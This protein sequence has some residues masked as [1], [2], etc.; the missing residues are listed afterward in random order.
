MK[1]I[2]VFGEIKDGG[3][4]PKNSDVYMEKL[5]EAGDVNDCILT[6]TGA[7]K[8]SPDQNNYAFAMCNVIAK[9]VNQDGWNFTAY[10][11]Y[12]KIEQEY[13]WT[14]A[15]N[16]ETGSTAKYLKPLKKHSPER[17]WEIIE[18]ARLDYMQRLDIDIQTPA[19][20]YGMTEKAYDLWK[21]GAITY[22]KAKKM[23]NKS[24]SQQAK[25]E[26]SNVAPEGQKNLS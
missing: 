16:E 7:N 6:I 8:R 3:F 5:R 21:D 17:F 12:K 15:T 20:Y 14:V 19:Q 13:C 2:K 23:S 10:D 1:E 4:W 26:I 9:R 18:E 22:A 25:E 11:V 24:A